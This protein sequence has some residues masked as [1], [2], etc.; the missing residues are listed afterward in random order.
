MQPKKNATKKK[1]L[2]VLK[3]EEMTILELLYGC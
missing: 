2:N 3:V 1:S